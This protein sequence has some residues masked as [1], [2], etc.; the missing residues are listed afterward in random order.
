MVAINQTNTRKTKIDD[1]CRPTATRAHLHS[2]RG[3]ALPSVLVIAIVISLLAITLTTLAQLLATDSSA[4]SSAIDGRAV[5][6]AGLNRIILAYARRG[7]LLREQLLPDGRPVSWEFRGKSLQLRAQA[8]SGKL[9]LNAAD[10][11]HIAALLDRLIDD[12]EMRSQVLTQIDTARQLGARITSVAA[13]LSPF[14]RMTTKLDLLKNYFTVMT[15]QRGI[16]PMTAPPLLI[17]TI[18]GLSD[19]LK[20]LILDARAAR[21][22]LPLAEV[23]APVA[24]GFAGERPIYTF[25]AQTSAGSDRAIAMGAVVGFSEQ[26]GTSIYAWAPEGVQK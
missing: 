4:F 24:Q 2:E 5:T 13:V 1:L 26:S 3:F 15:D 7:D 6:E 8:E 10:R 20:T 17:A 22:P 16:D 11:V 14:D 18:P 25:H 9:D 19:S 21:R 12:P 23:P